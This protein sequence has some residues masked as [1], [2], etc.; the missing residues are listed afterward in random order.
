MTANE[1]H[2]GV[3]LSVITVVKDDPAG[4]QRTLESVTIQTRPTSAEAAFEWLVIDGSNEQSAVPALLAIAD[5][6]NTRC[7]WSA[8]QGVY[9]AMNTGL[10]QATGDY[11]LFLN[12]GENCAG[13]DL[14]GVSDI[15]LYHAMSPSTHTQI[16]GRG[17]RICR[18]EPL[19]VHNLVLA[20]DE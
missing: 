9:P 16:V 11:V 5:N 15:I 1:G 17:K 2:V 13:I 18:T 6:P 14:P 3:I 10:A 19:A 20:D 8:P 7:Q 4:F 12:A